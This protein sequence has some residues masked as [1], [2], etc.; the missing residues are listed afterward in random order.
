MLWLAHPATRSISH[1]SSNLSSSR[2]HSYHHHHP[3]TLGN[4]GNYYSCIA[5]A[6]SCSRLPNVVSG[7]RSPY[8]FI[9]KTMFIYTIR[10]EEVIGRGPPTASHYPRSHDLPEQSPTPEGEGLKP[11]SYSPYDIPQEPNGCTHEK[12]NL[13]KESSHASI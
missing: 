13:H 3:L 4:H 12:N 5:A 10:P 9:R 1:S 11:K 2:H 8:R 6:C 7:G